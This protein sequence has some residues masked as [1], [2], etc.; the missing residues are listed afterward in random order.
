M[1]AIYTKKLDLNHVQRV[2]P[3]VFTAQPK[4]TTSNDYLFIPTSKILTGLMDNGFSIVA[5]KQQG[6][7]KEGQ[8][9]YAKH[10]I[11]LMHDSQQQELKQNGEYPLLRLQNSHDAKSSFQLST[12]IFRLVCSNGI[13]IPENELNSARIVHNLNTDQETIEA[14][15]KVISNHQNELE[16]IDNMKRIELTQDEKMLLADSSKRLIFDK[17]IVALND[18]AKIDINRKLLQARR[19]DDKASDLWTVFNVIQENAIRGGIQIARPSDKGNY[20]VRGTDERMNYR[21][22]KAVNSIDSDKKINIELMTLAQEM[23]K[24]KATA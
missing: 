15:F 20:R 14:S 24:I 3:A 6:S 1:S 10:V 17:D 2:A 19:R 7:R 22:T 8:E 23:A 12:G 5:V 21:R 11:H 18:R 4:S 13:V 16:M 9:L